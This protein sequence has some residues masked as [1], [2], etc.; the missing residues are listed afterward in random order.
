MVQVLSLETVFINAMVQSFSFSNVQSLFKDTAFLKVKAFLICFYS[1]IV[2]DFLRPCSYKNWTTLVFILAPTKT[3]VIFF[4][5]GSK[6]K[7]LQLHC[8]LF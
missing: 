4:I 1:L 8:Q 2:L 6:K 7:G 3:L 5:L